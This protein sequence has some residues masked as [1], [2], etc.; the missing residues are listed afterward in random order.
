MKNK[1]NVDDIKNKINERIEH[2]KL[3]KANP[4]GVYHDEELKSLLSW[5]KEQELKEDFKSF[6]GNTLEVAKRPEFPKGALAIIGGIAVDTVGYTDKNGNTFVR[7]IYIINGYDFNDRFGEYP[8]ELHRKRKKGFLSSDKLKELYHIPKN[9]KFY[10]TG[11]N[12]QKEGGYIIYTTN[13]FYP[14]KIET[15]E[16]QNGVTWAKL[17]QSSTGKIKSWCDFPLADQ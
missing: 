1:I 5:I 3:W 13:E 10:R 6:K 8:T 4:E 11:I 17:T 16:D 7:D 2:I 15:E 9:A 14:E 12:D